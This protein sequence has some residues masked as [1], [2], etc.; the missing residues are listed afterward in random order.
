M[1]FIFEGTDGTGKDTQIEKLVDYFNYRNIF[2]LVISSS[3][4]HCN[5]DK[6]K[7]R[8]LSLNRYTNLF[9]FIDYCAKSEEVFIFNRCHLSEY[10]YS[11][12]YRNYDGYFVFALENNVSKEMLDNNIVLI[13]FIGDA[14]QVLK[15]DT[16]RG[17]NKS[18]SYDIEMRKKEI[19]KFEEAHNLSR[20]AHK[21]IINI[22]NKS[23]DKIHKEVISYYKKVWN[24]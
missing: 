16:E 7:Y 13:T 5:V 1:V 11:P 9:S 22:T 18:F 3:N 24:F 14:G 20:I 17:D 2:P 23:I 6:V 4:L 19:D 21:T 12:L 10:V 8:E 15:R